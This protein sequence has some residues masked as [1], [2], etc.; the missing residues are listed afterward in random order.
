M[1]AL[2]PLLFLSLLGAACGGAGGDE[3]HAPIP[4]GP[5]SE[6]G[7]PVGPKPIDP[8]PLPPSGKHMG[9]VPVEAGI[10]LRVWAPNAKAV[11]AVGDFGRVE[12][13]A[14]PGG[15]WAKT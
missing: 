12:L 9:A 1:L 15:T 10:E 13:D 11:A 8:L 3:A 14:E 6:P 4:P 5:V 2:R 7:V